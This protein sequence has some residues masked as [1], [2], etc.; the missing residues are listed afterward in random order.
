MR[1]S[2]DMLHGPFRKAG[3]D[4]KPIQFGG[5][6]RKKKEISRAPHVQDG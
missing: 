1:K 6:R 4:T 5:R 2:L 3:R